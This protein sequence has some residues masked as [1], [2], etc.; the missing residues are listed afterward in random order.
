[1]GS[2]PCVFCCMLFSVV[3]KVAHA[4]GKR[5]VYMI[6]LSIYIYTRSVCEYIMNKHVESMYVFLHPSIS[7]YQ[8]TGIYGCSS[9]SANL[10]KSSVPSCFA[11]GQ[12]GRHEV[13]GANLWYT[14]VCGV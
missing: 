4:V 11:K 12:M 6:I 10:R 9:P 1:M 7:T 5:C 3:R 2:V 14:M 13:D 8:Y